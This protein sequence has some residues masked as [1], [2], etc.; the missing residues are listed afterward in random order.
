MEDKPHIMV[1]DDDAG[2]CI[3]LVF[4]LQDDYSIVTVNSAQEG[5]AKMKEGFDPAVIL[6]DLCM[7]DTYGLDVLDELRLTHADIPIIILTGIGDPD[8][9]AATLQHGAFGYVEK[10][11]S[12]NRLVDVIKAGVA[13][14]RL[15][16]GQSQ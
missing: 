7:P 11:F 9:L 6:L 15:A 5:I 16:L 3:S 10:P 4:L 8:I 12:C 14:H 2:V 1:I 13:S